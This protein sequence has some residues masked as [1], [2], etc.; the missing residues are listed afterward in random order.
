MIQKHLFYSYF[1][2]INYFLNNN[3]NK[4]ICSSLQNQ[5][6]TVSQDPSM[7]E[8]LLVDQGCLQVSLTARRIRHR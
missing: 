6:E 8:R 4:R 3:N 2:V 7:S 1:S 5:G